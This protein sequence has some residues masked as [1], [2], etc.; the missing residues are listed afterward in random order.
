MTELV[1]ADKVL[2]CSKNNDIKQKF[3]YLT[4]KALQWQF[5]TMNVWGIYLVEEVKVV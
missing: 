3:Q 5:A 2:T 1:R 4:K